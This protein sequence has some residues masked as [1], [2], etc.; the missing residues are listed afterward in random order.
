MGTSALLLTRE[1]RP[2]NGPRPP[3]QSREVPGPLDFGEAGGG[4]TSRSKVGRSEPRWGP[5]SP[6]ILHPLESFV[7]HPGDLDPQ[8]SLLLAFCKAVQN[9]V[10]TFTALPKGSPGHPRT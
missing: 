10:E 6:C 3:E 8:T 7:K 1:N 2:V 9:V 4:E 5:L